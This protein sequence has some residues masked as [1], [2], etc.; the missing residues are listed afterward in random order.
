MTGPEHY[1]EAERLLAQAHV[2]PRDRAVPNW[3][4]ADEL[5]TEAQVHATLALAAAYA[6]VNPTSAWHQVAGMSAESS[7]NQ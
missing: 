6:E 2:H 3:L 1:A 4:T 7:S 5:S